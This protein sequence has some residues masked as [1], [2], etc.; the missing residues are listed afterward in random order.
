LK[1]FEQQRDD[2]LKTARKEEEALQKQLN[3]IQGLIA[4]LSG[5]AATPVEGNGRR[6][7]KNG[8]RKAAN[9]RRKGHKMSAA[10][11][12]AIA[13]AQRLRWAKQKKE[14]AKEKS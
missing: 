13:E 8:R 7:P 14:K 2:L 4:A 1:Q 9:G 3:E 6:K 12:K 11:R 10:G 5:N